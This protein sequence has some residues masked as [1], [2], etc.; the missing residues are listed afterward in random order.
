MEI[1]KN[2]ITEYIQNLDPKRKEDMLHLIDLMEK[3]THLKPK[4]WGSIVGF[5]K[6]HYQFKTGHSGDMPIIGLASR[7]QAITLYLSFDI[8]AYDELKQLGLVTY[9]KSCLYIKSLKDVN[10]EILKRLIEKTTVDAL[11]YDFITR[12][13]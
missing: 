3:I 10:L 4:L 12:I 6:L 5:G 7:K 2:D 11:K 9:S 1:T 13:E 8:G